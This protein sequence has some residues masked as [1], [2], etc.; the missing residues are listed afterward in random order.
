M[1]HWIV[2][3]ILEYLI[4]KILHNKISKEKL[5]INSLISVN[6]S[7]YVIV[8]KLLNIKSKTWVYNYIYY[9]NLFRKC[10]IFF[11]LAKNKLLLQDYKKP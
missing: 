4:S 8:F 1:L 11:I 3:I 10:L 7:I 6:S 5:I 2:F 9:N